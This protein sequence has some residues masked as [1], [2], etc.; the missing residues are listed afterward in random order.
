MDPT[1]H[2]RRMKRWSLK[3]TRYDR[4]SAEDLVQDACLDALGLVYDPRYASQI[5]VL[6]QIMRNRYLKN[7]YLA[8]MQKRSAQTVPIDDLTDK[9]HPYT[10][11]RQEQIVYA[12]EMAALARKL[13]KGQ[14]RALG[15]AIAGTDG[16]S[17][18][19]LLWQARRALGREPWEAMK[20][21]VRRRA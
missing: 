11:P 15:M 19:T 14:Q 4:D 5:T 13:T 12:C 20:R 3:W 10:A 18:R 1:P 17:E 9:F 6:Y 7:I 21:E 8:S 16:R 2:L